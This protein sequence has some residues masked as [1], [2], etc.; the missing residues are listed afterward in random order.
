VLDPPKQT[1]RRWDEA[2]TSPDVAVV[3]RMAAGSLPEIF[4]LGD[5]DEVFVKLYD[6]PIRGHTP[7][8][9]EY[10][11]AGD[12]GGQEVDWDEGDDDGDG[13]GDG[14]GEVEVD[15]EP[16]APGRHAFMR[17]DPDASREELEAMARRFVDQ[18]FGRGAS[19]VPSD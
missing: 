13:D 10:A 19:A 11:A 4:G 9:P 7:A 18:L 2:T 16:P 17:F 1:N 8:S 14:D 12:E 15:E 6:L 5:G 3:A